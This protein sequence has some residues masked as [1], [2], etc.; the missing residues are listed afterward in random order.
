MGSFLI[1]A[2]GVHDLILL[3]DTLTLLPVSE[4]MIG[5]EAKLLTKLGT[6]SWRMHRKP[7]CLGHFAETQG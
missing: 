2:I 6:S 5:W 3:R 1:T 4:G 7:S